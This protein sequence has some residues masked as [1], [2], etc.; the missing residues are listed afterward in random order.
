MLDV[1]ID[2]A[3]ALHE[4]VADRAADEA[5]PVP[6]QILAHGIRFWRRRRNVRQGAWSRPRRIR[7]E[8]PD[9][10]IERAE[11]VARLEERLR[12]RDGGGHLEPVADDPD[13]PQQAIDVVRT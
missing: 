4:G 13:V 3:G 1:V 10:G 12:V 5:E 9:I 11:L 6:L 8:L 7:R 2:E